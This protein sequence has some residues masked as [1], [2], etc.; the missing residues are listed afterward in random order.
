MHKASHRAVSAWQS[1]TANRWKLD[2]G[3]SAINSALHYRNCGILSCTGTGRGSECRSA[4]RRGKLRGA[5]C[6]EGRGV[7]GGCTPLGPRPRPQKGL[8]ANTQHKQG[9]RANSPQQKLDP[10]LPPNENQIHSRNNHSTVPRYRSW[11]ERSIIVVS[12]KK[13]KVNADIISRVGLFYHLVFLLEKE[14]KAKG[15]ARSGH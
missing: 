7:P 11:F 15:F 2:N 9:M 12:V 4:A 3:R 13:K 8:T 6:R 14:N 5:V 1:L 10:S